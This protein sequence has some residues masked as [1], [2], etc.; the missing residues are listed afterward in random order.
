VDPGKVGARIHGVPVVAVEEAGRLRGPLH[1]AAVGQKGARERIR[2]E[3][4]R[5]G[6]AE[7]TD[8]VAV[9]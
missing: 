2:V 4:V 8:L 1:L 9:A 7:G 5:I 6:L 3:A